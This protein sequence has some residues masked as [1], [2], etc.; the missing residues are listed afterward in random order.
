MQTIEKFKA[1]L[2]LGLNLHKSQG[3][4]IE[5]IQLQTDLAKTIPW[6]DKFQILGIN[7]DARDYEKKEVQIN[8][9]PAIK[10]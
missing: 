3:I 7:F 10:K 9:G 5:D 1:V 4:V 6:G 8:F 2:G